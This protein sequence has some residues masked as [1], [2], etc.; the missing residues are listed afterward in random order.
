MAK[1]TI[2]GTDY[3]V[4]ELNFVGLEKAW[5]F[6]NEA[7][8]TQDPMK[9]PSAGLSVIAA[10]LV[11]AEDFDADKFNV[12]KDQNLTEDEMFDYIVSF[13]KRKLRAS[14]IPNIITCMNQI[15][16]EAGLAP[17]EDPPLPPLETEEETPSTVTAPATSASLSQPDAKEAAGKA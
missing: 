6:I 8:V 12:P 14:E 11:Y 10:G 4:P 7:M 5:P 2:G 16:E 3:T 9:G 15:T 1:C 17:D 13:L